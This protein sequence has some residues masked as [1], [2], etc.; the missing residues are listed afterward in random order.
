MKSKAQKRKEALE[1]AEKATYGNSKAK[2]N[3]V[4]KEQWTENNQA[5]IEHL[6]A[7]KTF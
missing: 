7:I 3:G 1:R 4:S 6:E 5:H 2:R